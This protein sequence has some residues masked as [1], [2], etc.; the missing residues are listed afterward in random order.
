MK[1]KIEFSPARWAM[2]LLCTLLGLVFAVMLCGTLAFQHL[3]GKLN[4]VEPVQPEGDGIVSAFS[5]INLGNF[6]A[7]TQDNKVQSAS[8]VLNI[9]L[10]G[11]DRREG[12]SQARSDSMILCTFNKH[13][14]QLTM[15][16]FLRDLYVSIPGYHDNR[17]NAAYSEGGISLLRETLEQNFGVEIDGTVE[18]DFTQFSGIVDLLG[19]VEI[20]LRQDEANVINQETGGALEAGV[21]TLNGMEALA[22]SRI[23]KLDADGD[24]SR[25]NRQRKVINALIDSLRGISLKEM[26]PVIGKILPMLTTDLNR[27]QLLL[28]AL[29]I[30]PHLS[31]IDIHS[32][33]IPAD[34]TFTDKTIDGMSVLVTDMEIQQKYLQDT[35]LR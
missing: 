12:E 31:Q 22:Y 2:K 16:S 4:Y 15:T 3:L 10:V 29:E 7:D 23:R 24:F 17:I 34:G 21:R 11:Q 18:V 13:T 14:K 1:R 28:Y 26:T 5:A 33:K 27:G 9:L 6:G 8:G 35:L 19:G 25:T 32:Q 20:E 30:L